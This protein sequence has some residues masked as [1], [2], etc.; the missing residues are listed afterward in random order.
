MVVNMEVDMVADME[1]DKV[2]DM[3]AGMAADKKVA[4]MELDTGGRHEG[5]KQGGRHGG[6]K[7]KMA[8]MKNVLKQSVL[9]RS[10]LMRSAP[11]LR[12]FNNFASLFSFEGA[13]AEE[14]KL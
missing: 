5:K 2:A 8:E 6:R 9:G 10:C 7:N 11:D 13:D 3:V 1:V 14:G 4:N 12:V